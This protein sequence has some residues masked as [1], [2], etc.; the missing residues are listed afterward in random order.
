MPVDW[1]LNY[2]L[3]EVWHSSLGRVVALRQPKHWFI[4]R[5]N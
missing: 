3:N 4:S 5:K 1:K 2:E